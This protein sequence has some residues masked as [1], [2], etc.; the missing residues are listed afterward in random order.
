[1]ISELADTIESQPDQEIGVLSQT[2][3]SLTTPKQ[4]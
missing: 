2:T 1:M 4:Q 3:I